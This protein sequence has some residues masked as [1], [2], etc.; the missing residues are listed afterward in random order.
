MTPTYADGGSFRQALEA[1]LR[2][3]AD[4]GRIPL[5]T[6]R[7]KVTMERLLARLFTDDDPGWR[8]KDGYAMELRLHH[9]ARTT[10][11]LV[12]QQVPQQ[13]P[14]DTAFDPR[15]GALRRGVRH[16][17]LAADVDDHDPFQHI[18]SP[19]GVQRSGGVDANIR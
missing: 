16:H 18:F 19:L 17:H 2:R 8:L 7:Q 5:N 9:R 10:R 1:H 6:L 12:G 14:F 11:E 4:E 15:H 3:A 13:L